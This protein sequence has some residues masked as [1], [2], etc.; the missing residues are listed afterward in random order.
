M[1][2]AQTVQCVDKILSTTCECLC[3]DYSTP[4]IHCCYRTISHCCSSSSS[5]CCRAQF[6]SNFSVHTNPRRYESWCFILLPCWW[7]SSTSPVKALPLV[8]LLTENQER[9]TAFLIEQSLHVLRRGHELGRGHSV[10]KVLHISKPISVFAEAMSEAPAAH[11]KGDLHGWITNRTKWETQQGPKSLLSSLC[12][13]NVI[14][15]ISLVFAALIV[16]SHAAFS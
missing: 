6:F 1:F 9:N 11:V 15:W 4:D 14:Y 2:L 7:H 5:E 13:R 16:C 10:I 12:V 3:W 8:Y